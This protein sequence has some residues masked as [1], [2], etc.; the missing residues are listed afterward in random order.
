M[1]DQRRGL[2]AREPVVSTNATAPTLST[3]DVRGV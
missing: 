1:H 2:R 3:I